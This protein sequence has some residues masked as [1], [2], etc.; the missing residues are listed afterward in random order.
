MTAFVVVSLLILAAW[1]VLGLLA[2]FLLAAR[3]RQPGLIICALIIGAWVIVT[4]ISAVV[5]L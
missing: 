2:P 1:A 3:A 5:M 4:L